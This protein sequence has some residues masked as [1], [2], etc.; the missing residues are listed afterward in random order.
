[1]PKV[2]Q[3]MLGDGINNMPGPKG[4]ITHLIAPQ[5]ALR[6]AFVPGNFSFALSVGVRDVNL[7][8]ENKIKFMITSPN[9]EAIQTSEET[10]IP[11]IVKDDA[12]PIEYQGFVLNLDV[13]NLAIPVEGIYKFTIFVNGEAME[14]QDIPIYK[15]G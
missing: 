1:M 3:F 2:T 11:A 13:R 5:V 15:G 4:M 6:P 12:L 9:G 8:Q 7:Q 10:I 14:A